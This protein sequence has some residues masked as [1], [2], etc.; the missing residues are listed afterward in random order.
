MPKRLP[1]GKTKRSTRTVKTP[2]RRAV[3]PA[4][5][6]ESA[7]A[8]STPASAPAT[9]SQRPTQLRQT[10]PPP[11]QSLLN[12][13]RR[14]APKASPALVTDYGYVTADLKRIGVVSA[15]AFAILV[16]LSFVIR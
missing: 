3:S 14:P 11:R 1:S 2:E 6:G 8:A 15:A 5:G 13:T 10:A 16:V 12:T 9:V 4:S 7:Q